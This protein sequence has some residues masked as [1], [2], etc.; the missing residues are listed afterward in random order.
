MIPCLR[1]SGFITSIS[2]QIS[3]PFSK[4]LFFLFF[5]FFDFVVCHAVPSFSWYSAASKPS[6]I[7]DL[8]KID[9]TAQHGEFSLC[10]KYHLNVAS[11][12][13]P[14]SSCTALMWVLKLTFCFIGFV[15]SRCILVWFLLLL[16]LLLFFVSLVLSHLCLGIWHFIMK[17]YCFRR[18]CRN[19]TR[20]DWFGGGNHGNMRNRL[21]KNG[22]L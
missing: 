8:N 6:T 22:T 4:S 11:Q 20:I 2:R 19:C 18:E 7:H 14:G 5:C 10:R 1:H 15:A 13:S 21:E 16:L 12:E 17:F 9:N 3:L